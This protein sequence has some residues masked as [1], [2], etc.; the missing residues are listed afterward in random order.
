MAAG[1]EVVAAT[2]VALHVA[3]DAEGLAAA[4]V[5]ALEGLL[6][7]VRVAVNTQRAGP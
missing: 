2:L 7:G 4:R 6:A 5:W 3:P 1:L